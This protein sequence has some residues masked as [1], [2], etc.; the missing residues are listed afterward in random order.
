MR[1]VC[2]VL[3]TELF[4]AI[5][6][7]CFNVFYTCLPHFSSSILDNV[8][9]AHSTQF[10]VQSS[11]L[12]YMRTYEENGVAHE[13]I[14]IEW[15]VSSASWDFEVAK[16]RWGRAHAQCK[17]LLFCANTVV[18]E[19]AKFELACLKKEEEEEEEE[20]R[21]WRFGDFLVRYFRDGFSRHWESS[22]PGKHSKMNSKLS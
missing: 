17:M 10:W 12:L 15:A 11:K 9:S 8:H 21:F 20:N 18:R 5:I 1:K 14:V 13:A 19:S 2:R 22:L 4:Y 16:K 6:P 3:Y 7:A